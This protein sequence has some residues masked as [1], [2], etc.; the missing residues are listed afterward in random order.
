MDFSLSADQ[1][2]I[3]TTL[4]KLIQRECPRETA[5]ELD[6]EGGFPASVLAKIAELGLCGLNT[7]E[8]FGGSGR[9]LVGTAMALEEI[10]TASPALAML[11]A[12]VSIYGGCA[13]A[14]FGSPAQQMAHLPQCAGAGPGFGLALADDLAR[15]G[16]RV[17]SNVNTLSLSGRAAGVPFAS[18]A[19]IG[20]LLAEARDDNDPNSVSIFI[21]PLDTPGLRVEATPTIGMRGLGLG[22]V[23]FDKVALEPEQVLGGPEYL[24]RGAKQRAYLAALDQLCGAAIGLGLTQGAQAYALGY[25]RERS[26]FGQTLLQFEAVEHML[27]DLA[28]EAQSAR[29]LLY[30][31]C[32]LADQDKPFLAEAA[33]ARLR[34]GSLAR[35]A[36]LQSVRIL[37]GYGYMAEYD[38]QRSMRDGLVLIPGGESAEVL[39]TRI[40]QLLH[41]L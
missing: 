32:W 37:G 33:M 8:A 16:A 7:P 38:A 4:R 30:H 34:L 21:V 27:V 6:E 9:D 17:T 3:Q 41:N 11:F 26:Q 23:F 28:V 24:G 36:G 29:W 22:E 14:Q 2:Y 1:A 13:L 19:R 35:Q 20:Y 15:G 40:G 25:A 5:H 39:K 18:P 12:S 31:A 10:A